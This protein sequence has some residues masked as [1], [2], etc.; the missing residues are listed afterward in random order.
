MKQKPIKHHMDGLIALLLFGVF[1]VC[2]LAVLLTGADA[3]RRLTQ[4]DRAAY[5]RRTCVQYVATR[6]RQSD[7]LDGVRLEEFNG[8][9][10][11]VL[12]AEEEYVTRIYCHDGWIM[13][14]YCAAGLE[15]DTEDG[16][17]VMAAEGLGFTLDDGL[18][19][20]TATDSQGTEQTLL[21]SLRGGEGETP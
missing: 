11:L 7:R 18:L 8:T 1:A 16:E 21:L 20:I 15:M 12:D 13:E 10:C 3:Y 6:V 5:E 2:I 14:L 4:R 9:D 17:P 19:T